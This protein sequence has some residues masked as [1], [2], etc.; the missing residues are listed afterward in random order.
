MKFVDTAARFA[1]AIKVVKGTLEVDGKSPMEMM[2]LEAVQ[3]TT[4]KLQAH[5]SDC[6]EALQALKDLIHSKFGED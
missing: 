3:G 6:S 4:L 1:S 5:G 2:L